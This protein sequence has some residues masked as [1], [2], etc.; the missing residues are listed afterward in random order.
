MLYDNVL[1]RVPDDAGYNNWKQQMESGMTREELVN[2][3]L[4]SEEFTQICNLF[5][6]AP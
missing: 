6:V 1:G 4:S 2:N 3:F 5:N